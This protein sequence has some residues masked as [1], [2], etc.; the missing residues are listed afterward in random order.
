MINSTLHVT[1]SS[2]DSSSAVCG[3]AIYATAG[4]VI[5]QNST[6]RKNKVNNAIYIKNN[7]LINTNIQSSNII[8]TLSSSI[9]NDFSNNIIKDFS[10]NNI[11]DFSRDIIKNFIRD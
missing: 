9:I 1:N 2:L 10:S 11:K 8:N 4:S 6:F 3:G 5:I 7:Y